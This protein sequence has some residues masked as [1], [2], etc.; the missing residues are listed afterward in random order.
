M[1]IIKSI[2]LKVGIFFGLITIVKEKRIIH[3][4]TFLT[5]D[6]FC[7]EIFK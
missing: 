1:N 3:H 5:M 4:K 6:D 7:K 2:L